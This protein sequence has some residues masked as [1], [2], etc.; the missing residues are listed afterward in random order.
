M[1]LSILSPSR[2]TV[3]GAVGKVEVIFSCIGELVLLL[4]RR[5]ESTPSPR[6]IRVYILR[7][8]TAE[9]A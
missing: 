7:L 6:T 8:G 9:N 1:A 5:R 3:D 4:I 2:R